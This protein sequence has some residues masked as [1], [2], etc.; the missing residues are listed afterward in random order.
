MGGD[1]GV[2]AIDPAGD[3]VWSLNTPGMFRARIAE[4]GKLEVHIYADEEK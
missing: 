2:I 4:G 3:M 1:G